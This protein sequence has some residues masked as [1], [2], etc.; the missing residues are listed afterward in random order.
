MRHPLATSLTI[1]ALAVA[2]ALLLIASTV[3]LLV[4][5]LRRLGLAREARNRLTLEERLRP[6]ALELLDEDAEL[7]PREL[8]ADEAEVFAELLGRYGRNVR[9]SVAARLE[10]WFS[11]S[12]AFDVTI[13]RLR[14][15][16]DWQRAA[17]AYALGDMASAR[18]APDLL[19]ALGD[20]DPV[21]RAAA[22]RSLGRL[23]AT[24]A[25]EPL[26]EAQAEGRLPH[27]VAG[28]ALLAIGPSALP[29]LLPLVTVDDER[30]RAA[31]VELVGLIGGAVDARPLVAALRDASAAVRAQ[32]ALALGRLGSE[33]AAARLRDLLD[34]RIPFV[35]AAAAEAL[36]AVG[37]ERAAPR[38]R[39]LAVD[40]VFEPARA[41]A[42]ALA[43]VRPELVA[44]GGSPYLDEAA[45]LLALQLGSAGPAA[46]PTV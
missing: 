30:E 37:D 24:E 26:L 43:R 8:A 45:D 32:A 15:P 29:R 22:A 39:E 7:A 34:D 38:L 9:G 18:A 20:E 10:A 13:E 25:V 2:A 21:V 33:E 19:A 4:L 42:H 11:S 12:G 17:A 46:S 31:A 5:V 44:A 3:F 36:G 40:D 27:L 41:A 16:K 35:R 23:A 1:D 6:L 28:Q 14:S